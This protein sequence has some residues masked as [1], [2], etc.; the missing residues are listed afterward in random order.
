MKQL[1]IP[2]AEIYYWPL[3]FKTTV[4]NQYFEQLLTELDWQEGHI[5][6]FGKKISIPRLQAWYGDEGK[7]YKY[8]GVMMLPKSWT[9]T[10]LLIKKEIQTHLSHVKINSV[11]ANLYRTGQD[12]MGW[13][14]DN[15]QELGVNPEIFSVSFG[16]ERKFDLKPIS[17][18]HMTKTSIKLEHGSLLYMKNETQKNYKHQLPK[19]SNC[20]SPRINLTFRHIE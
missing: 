9:P 4:A 14:S 3:F 6:L 5:K 19:Q 10:L 11:L 15:E 13:H 20:N 2:N 16:C 8:S 17:I 18:P 1:E 12:S 7:M